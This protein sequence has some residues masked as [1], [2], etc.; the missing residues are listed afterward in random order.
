MGRV[1]P[2]ILQKASQCLEKKFGRI[3]YTNTQLAWNTQKVPQPSFWVMIP[4]NL[5]RSQ[6]SARIQNSQNLTKPSG[7]YSSNH[8]V[9]RNYQVYIHIYRYI[10]MQ[11]YRNHINPV[12]KYIYR[13]I[14]VLN[15]PLKSCKRKIGSR[16]HSPN[17]IMLS[18]EFYFSRFNTL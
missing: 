10:H 5:Q 1:L 13:Y 11:I 2:R 6:I 16:Y 12:F 14:F 3:C 17:S 18:F 9:T 4:P 15:Y 8:R 7:K